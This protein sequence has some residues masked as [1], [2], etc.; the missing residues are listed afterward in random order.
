MRRKPAIDWQRVRLR[1]ERAEAAVEQSGPADAERVQAI[2]RQRA[3]RLAQPPEIDRAGHSVSVLVFGM[4]S[5]RYGIELPRLQEVISRPLRAPVPGAPPQL[6]G[7]VSVRG[8]IHPVWDLARLLG[9][10]DLPA[11]TVEN[12]LLVRR[13]PRPFGLRTGP[14]EGVREIQP[15]ECGPAPPSARHIKWIAPDLLSI[16]DTEKLLKEDAS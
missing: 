1:L 10:P 11:D 3:A 8:E 9:L 13:A 2:L 7:V 16:L 12:V 14:V 6:A 5:E 4:G 15:A